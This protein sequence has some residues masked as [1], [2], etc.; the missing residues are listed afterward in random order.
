MIGAITEPPSVF[1]IIDN[2][3][4]MAITNGTDPTGNRFT[5]LSAFIDTVMA[6]FPKAEVGLAV[7]SG[8]LYYSPKSKPNVFQTVTTPTMGLDDTGAFVP[9]LTL[10]RQYGDQTGYEI[11]KEVLAVSNGSL[12]YPS[13]LTSQ[14]VGNIDCGFDAALQAFSQSTFS[15]G[16]QYI[17]FVY[18]GETSSQSAPHAFTAAR[19]CPTTFT[20]FFPQEP[21]SQA[22]FRRIPPIA[23][24]IIIHF[25][26]TILTP[27]HTTIPRSILSWH[28]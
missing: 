10:N 21:R 22:L 5:V 26:M 18:D 7:F 25:Q 11:L 27:G 15:P 14:Q 4:S 17:I 8:G 16:N 28:S 2:S 3:N 1:F 20:V 6:K 13:I 23:K 9:L 19:N 12:T 24:P